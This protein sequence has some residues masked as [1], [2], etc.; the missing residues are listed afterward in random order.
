MR[1]DVVKASECTVEDGGS[2]L[3]VP[4]YQGGFPVNSS[5]LAREDEVALQ[6]LADRGVLTGKASKTYMLPGARGPSGSVL[7]VGLGER[8]AYTPEVLRRAG[9]DACRHF[10]TN[11]VPRVYFDISRHQELEI[12]RAHV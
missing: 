12:G 2:C 10:G 6:A 7:T 1:I 5:V 9:G 4:V 11:R 3:A 8:E